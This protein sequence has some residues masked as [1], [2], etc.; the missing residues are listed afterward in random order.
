MEIEE[1][2]VAE[3]EEVL[4]KVFV[5]CHSMWLVLNKV[6]SICTHEM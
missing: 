4:D 6:L 2:E 3:E 5:A 1:E